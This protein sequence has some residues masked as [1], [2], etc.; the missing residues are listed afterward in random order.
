MHALS[1]L[2]LFLMSAGRRLLER[3]TSKYAVIQELP[4]RAV[5]LA[6][7]GGVMAGRSRI[8][9][10][11]GPIFFPIRCYTGVDQRGHGGPCGHQNV[12]GIQDPIICHVWKALQ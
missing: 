2:P 10:Y 7:Q 6:R 5:T 1:R 12:T 3:E 8:R 4:A 11:S 9:R